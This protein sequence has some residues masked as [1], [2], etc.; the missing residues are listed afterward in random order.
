MNIDILLENKEKY[1][2]LTID[3]HVR[4]W[5]KGTQERNENLMNYTMNE[6]KKNT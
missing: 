5:K 4:L 6:T 1:L 2:I 3:I